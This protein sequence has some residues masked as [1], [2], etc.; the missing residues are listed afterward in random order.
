[1]QCCVREIP[2][3]RRPPVSVLLGRRVVQIA[4][5]TV[6]RA[7]DGRTGTTVTKLKFRRRD[8]RNSETQPENL[9]SKKKAGTLG[10]PA[11]GGGSLRPGPA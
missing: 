3:C 9:C 8:S 11:S 4:A 2:E 6:T 5:L 10:A 1:M 7:Y